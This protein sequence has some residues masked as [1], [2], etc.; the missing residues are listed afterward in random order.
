M[1]FAVRC[2]YLGSVRVTARLSIGGE[3]LT[4][5]N[6]V[7]EL[8]FVDDVPSRDMSSV[9]GCGAGAARVN[10]ATRSKRRFTGETMMIC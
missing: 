3:S 7:L 5:A 1:L 6:Q 8:G 4:C 10:A 2:R 9:C